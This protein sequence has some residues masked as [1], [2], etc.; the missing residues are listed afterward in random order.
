MCCS[1]NSLKARL[2]S[3]IYIIQVN[4]KKNQITI[5][6]VRSLRVSRSSRL[7]DSEKKLKKNFKAKNW[8]QNYTLLFT[9][10]VL[11][12]YIIFNS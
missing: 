10:V 11:F 7:R 5:N 4:S 2:F 1:K 6:R 9:V 12:R 8:T 3:N